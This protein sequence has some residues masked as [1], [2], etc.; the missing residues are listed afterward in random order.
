MIDRG[1]A[2]TIP[3]GWLA[4]DPT[5]KIEAQVK[6]TRL[7]VH[8]LPATEVTGLRARLVQEQDEGVQTL[9]LQFGSPP[10]A[11]HSSIGRPPEGE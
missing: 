2:I 8:D 7:L 11:Q 5:A 10:R 9:A 4:F 6:R 1:F 3:E